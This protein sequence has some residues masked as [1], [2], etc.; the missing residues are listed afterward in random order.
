EFYYTVN[1]T[2]LSFIA[3]MFPWFSEH[4]ISIS[5]VMIV[6][7][8]VLGVM[9]LLGSKPK[10][11][12]WLFLLLVAFFTALTGFTYLTGHV[13]SGTNFFEFGKWGAWVETN[14]RVTDCGCFGDFL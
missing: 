5:V 7:E 13:P 1:E 12:S 3:P 9:L 8:I 4:S 11:T 6:F 14:M 2:W 10:L